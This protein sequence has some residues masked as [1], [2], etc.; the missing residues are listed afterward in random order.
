M[1]KKCTKGKRHRWT[2]VKNVLIEKTRVSRKAITVEI[3]TC[4]LYRCQ[5]GSEKFAET[6]RG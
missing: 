5:C 2:F 6:R 1:K 4:G 3:N